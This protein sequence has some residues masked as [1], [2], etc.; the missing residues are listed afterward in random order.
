MRDVKADVVLKHLQY[1]PALQQVRF[2]NQN[3]N[4]VISQTKGVRMKKLKKQRTPKGVVG[5][6]SRNSGGVTHKKKSGRG[7]HERRAK[8]KEDACPLFY[9]GMMTK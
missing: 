3:C 1:V 9:L 7:S 8:H 4:A 5:K 6:L 2:G